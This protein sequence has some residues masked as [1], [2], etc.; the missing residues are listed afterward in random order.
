[1]SLFKIIKIAKITTP[2]QNFEKGITTKSQF[3]L[4]IAII[5]V[6][7]FQLNE[8][9]KSS[10]SEQSSI[11]S[12]YHHRF[13]QKHYDPELIFCSKKHLDNFTH[14][15]QYIHTNVITDLP[16]TI[17]EIGLQNNSKYI[18]D[19]QYSARCG[20]DEI[21][22]KLMVNVS[23]IQSNGCNKVNYK[24]KFSKTT[25][26]PQPVVTVLGLL[27]SIAGLVDAMI[28]T[29][30]TSYLH[31]FCIH[32]FSF[33]FIFGAGNIDR[34][35]CHTVLCIQ[36]AM[37]LLGLSK[38]YILNYS[39]ISPTS[40]YLAPILLF[41]FVICMLAGGYCTSYSKLY[42]AL[43]SSFALLFADYVFPSLLEFNA[44]QSVHCFLSMVI[45]L[46]YML[47]S[48]V[49]LANFA[50]EQYLKY[51]NHAYIFQGDSTLP[52]IENNQNSML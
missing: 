1:M 13:S 48:L 4:V 19:A 8:F 31:L 7:I 45:S 44:E 42:T 40:M 35:I 33:L 30:N 9:S 6:L 5:V 39:E 34:T 11:A 16:C 50:S 36:C 26:Q 43:R 23:Q 51:R 20:A 29:A 2:Y 41:P 38:Q 49:C 37:S 47:F 22:W 27:I 52:M 12:F 21:S 24:L 28:R 3:L 15:L 17:T 46:T 32:I 14:Q 18:F 10:L 25:Y